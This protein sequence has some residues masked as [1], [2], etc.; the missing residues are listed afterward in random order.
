[1]GGQGIRG[2]LHNHGSSFGDGD[3]S[4]VGGWICSGLKNEKGLMIH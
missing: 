3:Y 4:V 1:V 2:R